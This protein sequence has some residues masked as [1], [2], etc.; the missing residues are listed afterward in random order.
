MWRAPVS[1]TVACRR[2]SGQTWIM[3]TAEPDSFVIS[4]TAGRRWIVSRAQ[5]FFDAL[6]KVRFGA[7]GRPGREIIALKL[8]GQFRRL[9]EE[10]ARLGGLESGKARRLQIGRAA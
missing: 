5:K 1:S 10:S 3:A 4:M 8:G 7:A 9:A 2:A 6:A